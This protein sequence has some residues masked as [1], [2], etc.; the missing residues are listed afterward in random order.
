MAGGHPNLVDEELRRFI[1]VNVVDSGSKA[2]NN[3]IIQGRHN[4]VPGVVEKFC[5]PRRNDLVVENAGGDPV[6]NIALP[7]PKNPNFEIH[8]QSRHDGLAYSSLG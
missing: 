4:M 5:G 1:G 6:K 7:R 8:T 3:P 2:H